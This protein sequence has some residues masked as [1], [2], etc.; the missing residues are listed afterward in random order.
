ASAEYALTLDRNL[1][2]AHAVVGYGKIHI[3]RAED[4]EAHV[5]EALRLSPLDTMAYVWMHTVG[6][7]SLH[8]GDYEQAIAWFRRSTEA[9][10]NLPATSFSLAAAFALLGRLNDAHSSVKAGLALNP[11]LTVSRLRAT[12][13]ARSDNS[14]FLTGVERILDGMRRAGLPEQ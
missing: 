10:R 5:D 4:T 14:T 6:T 1:A 12:W 2:G 11:T 7:A 8:L 3:G 13:T 9:N